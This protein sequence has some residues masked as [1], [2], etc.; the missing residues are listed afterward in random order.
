MPC[1]WRY[2]FLC[3]LRYRWLMCCC[4]DFHWLNLLKLE[5]QTYIFV[6]IDLFIEEVRSGLQNVQNKEL[7]LLFRS[8]EQ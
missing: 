2:F 4:Y 7:I 5:K 1:D 8:R 6:L 3:G